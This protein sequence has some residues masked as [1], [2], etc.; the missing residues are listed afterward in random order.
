M[1]GAV[2]GAFE[3]RAKL[4]GTRLGEAWRAV[5]RQTG[6]DVV[7]EVVRR[8]ICESAQVAA[9]NAVDA[10]INDARAIAQLASG[11]IA[12]VFTADIYENKLY[13]VSELLAGGNTLAER[14]V[15]GRMSTTQVAAIAHQ[16]ATALVSA[17]RSN[18]AHLDLEPRNIFLV[19]DPDQSS[20]E[21]VIV[22]G[23]GLGR[24]IAALPELGASP[25]MA[26]EIWQGRA[27]AGRGDS[28]SDIYAIG[29]L[30]FEMAAGRTPFAG[31]PVSLRTKH[32]TMEPPSIRSFAPDF[33]IALDKTI[34]R[35]L[36]KLPEE[37]PRM[38]RDVAKLFD[39]YAGHSA[40]LDETQE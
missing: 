14:L 7:I 22:S 9:T 6:G 5:H 17:G 4:R 30:A 35:M 3:V 36:G 27:V 20:K 39:M 32:L 37:R 24:I 31:D 21:R 18:I 1:V 12:K 11:H 19:P 16:I 29:C 23:F 25:Y 13:V 15:R 28:A 2:I 38:M 33:A 8:D 34:G 10:A 40:P 26:P